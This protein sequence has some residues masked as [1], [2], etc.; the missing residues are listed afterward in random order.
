MGTSPRSV[1]TG[2][3]AAMHATLPWLRLSFRVGVDMRSAVST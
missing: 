1:R 2:V 3:P